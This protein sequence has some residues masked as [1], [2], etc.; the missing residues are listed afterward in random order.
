[1]SEEI[2]LQ[3]AKLEASKIDARRRYIREKKKIQEEID[4]LNREVYQIYIIGC[5]RGI[6]IG[7]TGNLKQRIS[8]IQTGN[9]EP[10]SLEFVVDIYATRRKVIQIERSMHEWF[11]K[12]RKAGEW[13]YRRVKKRAIEVLS[14]CGDVRALPAA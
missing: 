8:S 9:P 12:D 13:F 5:S 11:D 2:Q 10:L 1:M 4:Q 3:I 7:M 14:H 6:K